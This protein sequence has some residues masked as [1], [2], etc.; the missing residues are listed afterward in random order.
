MDFV[1][2]HDEEEIERRVQHETDGTAWQ[3]YFNSEP[4]KAVRR[5]LELVLG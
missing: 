3:F 5:E 2:D 1:E 4:A